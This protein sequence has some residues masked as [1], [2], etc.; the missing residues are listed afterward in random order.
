MGKSILTMMS[1]AA[2]VLFCSGCDNGEEFQTPP[3]VEGIVLS[4]DE[5]VLEKGQKAVLEYVIQPD[6][7]VPEGEV[8]W[9]SDNE[10]CCTVSGGEVLAVSNG[11][12]SI[13]VSLDGFSDTCVV[14]VTPVGVETV[15]LSDSVLVLK[16]EDTWQLEAV[17]APEDAEYVP[18]WTTAD[19][20]VAGI[21]DA[22][23]VTAFTVGETVVTFTAG[24]KS[25]SC[26]VTVEPVKVEEVI[27]SET[28]LT[29]KVGES[30][31]LT[32]EVLPEDAEDRTVSW[33]SSDVSVAAVDGGVVT[34]VGIGHAVI[35]ASS[36]GITAE[37]SVAVE[38]VEAESITLS[39]NEC[40]LSVGD[41][42]VLTAVVMP[43]NT[44]DKTVIWSVDNP[45]VVSVDDGVITALSDGN[46]TV[47]ASVGTV[48]ADCY[49]TVEERGVVKPDWTVGELFDVKGYG[50]GI[51]FEAS[52]DHIKVVSIDQALLSWAVNPLYTS[53]YTDYEA[54]DCTEGNAALAAAE[55]AHPGNFP[56]YEWCAE[57]GAGWGLPTRKECE[58][59]YRDVRSVVES[60]VIDSGGSAFP[61]ECWTCIEDSVF[62]PSYAYT[63]G[64]YDVKLK[65]D[66]AGVLAVLLVQL[67]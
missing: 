30:A 41:T 36:G 28:Q 48:S 45:S 58:V 37:C 27:L 46:A 12:A 26:R 53:G 15:S 7:A 5:I 61:D 39:A 42:Y 11:T 33:S 24:D 4:R 54:V 67:Q 62:G 51:V 57:K 65:T 16:P 17:V 35:S 40:S 10:A 13:V 32:V 52:T 55:A 8:V 2:M 38:A 3:S 18:E 29:L 1:A 25:S 6:G 23:L 19:S 14:T 59:L 20:T 21:S 44:T 49:V 66:E 9:S 31:E 22:G 34:A 43:E 56:A 60:A 47:T 50:K 63:W 64:L